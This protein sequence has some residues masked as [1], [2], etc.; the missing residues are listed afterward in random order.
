MESLYLTLAAGVL[1]LLF[2]AFLARRLLAE[3]AGDEAM[4]RIGVAIQE[5]ASAFLKREYTFLAGSC[6]WSW[7][8][9]RCS[10]TS[11]RWTSSAT[12]GASSPT[13]PAPRSPT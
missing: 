7:S 1:A 9:W 4:Q 13:C 12:I 8:R 10:S 5:G 11:T 3:D 2:G 6:W